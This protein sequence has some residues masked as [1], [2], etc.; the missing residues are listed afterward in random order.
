MIAI[1]YLIE[2][3]QDPRALLQSAFSSQW[4]GRVL[5]LDTQDIERRT[6]IR[7]DAGWYSFNMPR[8]LIRAKWSAIEAMTTNSKF[9]CARQVTRGDCYVN[10]ASTTGSIA[11]GQDSDAERTALFR[12]D[13]RAFPA[14]LLR[15]ATVRSGNVITTVAHK[16]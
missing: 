6:N 2:Y 1:N 11:W 7:F 14:G 4:S 12:G 10:V 3:V 13:A 15:G 9:Q 8:N 5:C 16:P